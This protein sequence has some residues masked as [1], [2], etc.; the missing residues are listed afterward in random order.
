[1]VALITSCGREDLLLKTIGSLT[2]NQMEPLKI[3]I[4]EDHLGATKE[5]TLRSSLDHWITT[6]LTGGIGQHASIEKFLNFFER[7]AF[8]LHVEDD[9][10]FK[11]TYNWIEASMDIMLNH[12]DVIKVLA[13]EASPHPCSHDHILDHE[14]NIKYGFLQPWENDGIKWHGFSWN[15]GVTRLSML[16]QF[17]PFPKH[18]QE[19]AE[20]IYNAGYKVAEL[21]IPVYNH[22]GDGRS[23][24]I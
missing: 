19:L 13:R 20:R 23:T 15:P 1:M 4:H 12:P 5:N 2:M 10:E 8:Y 9:W 24:H 22:I 16:K 3:V 6:D 21:S 18:E 11:N 14:N 17:A 7:M